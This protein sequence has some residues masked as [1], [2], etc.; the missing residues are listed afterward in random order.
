MKMM[1]INWKGNEESDR[2]R[3]VNEGQQRD[4]KIKEERTKRK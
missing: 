3:K 2:M 1:G 4:M